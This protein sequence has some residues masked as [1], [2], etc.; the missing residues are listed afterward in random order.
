MRRGSASIIKS[1]AV[2]ERQRAT[3]GAKGATPSQV[4]R[5]VCVQP[6]GDAQAENT[7][8]QAIL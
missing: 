2:Q 1:L 3:K 8:L 5:P 7:P 6:A 4:V